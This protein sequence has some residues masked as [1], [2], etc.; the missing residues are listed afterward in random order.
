MTKFDEKP[1]NQA[2]KLLLVVPVLPAK[3]TFN[4][5]SFFAVPLLTAPLKIDEI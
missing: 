4:D 2:S 1:M 3:G 5:L